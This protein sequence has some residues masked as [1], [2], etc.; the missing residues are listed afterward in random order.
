MVPTVERGE[1][2]VVFCSM[3]MEGERPSIG[4]DVRPLH[5]VEKLPR[6]GG[7]RFDVA[8]LAFGVNSVECERGFAGA[9]KSGDHGQGVAR[10]FQADVLQIVLPGAPDDDF[11]QAHVETGPSRQ[12][13]PHEAA[14]Q[15]ALPHSEYNTARIIFQG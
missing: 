5:L 13:L 8:A 4:I 1:R 10:N 9:G 6:V 14:I 12:P 15:G 2:V 11:V 7:E 3:A